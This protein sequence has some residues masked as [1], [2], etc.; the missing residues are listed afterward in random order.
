MKWFSSVTAYARIAWRSILQ[1]RVAS[2]LTAVSMALGVGL[3]VMVLS[4]FGVVESSFRSNSSLGFNMVVGA[5]GGQEQ[6]VLNS[7]YYLSQPVENVPYQYY[8][9]FV[10]AEQRAADLKNSF[11]Y[12]T[13]AALT[14]ATS[15]A[16]LLSGLSGNFADVA[17]TTDASA[18]DLSLIE[19]EVARPGKYSRLVTHA[20]PLLLG[21]YFGRFR[22]IG[23]TSD[24]LGELSDKPEEGLN[25][26][27]AEGRNLEDWNQ[28][29][30]YFEAVVGSMVARE[31]N[32]KI[33][34]T[35]A[36]SHGQEGGDEH[37]ERFTIVGI[38]EPT[39]TPIDRGAYVNMEGFY[40]L[41]GHAKVT[42]EEELAEDSGGAGRKLPL[43]QREVT[44]V[45]VRTVKPAVAVGMENA[46]NEGTEA[47][48]V[49]P[50]KVIYNLFLFF[51][52]PIEFV[53]L[54]LTIVIC[55]VSGISILVSIYNSMNERRKEIAIMRALGAQRSAIVQIVLWES[56][57]LSLGGA[58]LGFVGGHVLLW[59]FSGM[60][61]AQSGVRIGLFD[62][63]PAIDIYSTYLGGRNIVLW[64][65][66]ELLLI[67]SV[68]LLALVVGSLPALSAYRTDVAEHL[69]D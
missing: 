21:D 65:Y 49:L 7:V 48:A 61:E 6:L 12:Q 62:L 41:E 20:V 23:T 36:I 51:V 56:L 28:E 60:I 22:V 10:P 69:A 16:N 59:L 66:P 38:L 32:V 26:S 4:L 29:H 33:G 30:G 44:A 55:V 47:Q 3:V 39:Y 40:L 34:D 27:F 9:E 15:T 46:I 58:V 19:Q 5:K 2:A 54:L 18:N 24:F 11:E 67:P 64:V 52:E 25:I 42:P 35:F 17:L 13:Q 37:G 45:L 50:V 31:Q 8:L 14:E 1:R 68:V 57:L 63:A 43:E 53:L